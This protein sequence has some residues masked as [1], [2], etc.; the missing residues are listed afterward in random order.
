M[1]VRRLLN[2]AFE[3]GLAAAVEAA[4]DEHDFSRRLELTSEFSRLKLTAGIHPLRV[5]SGDSG[6]DER[7]EL[8]RE[9]AA[10]P[11]VAGIGETGLDFFRDD[12]PPVLQ[13]RAFRDHLELSASLKKPVV[14]H[15]RSAD[16]R[17]LAIL[18]SSPGHSGVLHCFSSDWKTARGVIEA[19]FYVSFAGNLTYKKSDAIREA[20]AR[21]PLDRLLIETDSPYLSPQAVRGRNNHPGHIGF[22]LEYLAEIRN[23]DIEVLALN[24]IENAGRLFGF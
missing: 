9:Q 15:N 22:T 20:A 3:G 17:I 19:G 4:V 11:E 16:E 18:R 21:I 6:W 24:L 1:D 5:S 23:E 8:I 2:E 12:S 10:A 13:E 7:F 14:I